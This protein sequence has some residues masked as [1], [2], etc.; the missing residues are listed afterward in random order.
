[1]SNEADIARFRALIDACNAWNVQ[2]GNKVPG[3][4]HFDSGPND[5]TRSLTVSE[6]REDGVVLADADGARLLLTPGGQV[7]DADGKGVL[8]TMYQFCPSETFLSTAD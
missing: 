4:A 2:V 3:E 5:P 6:R 7:Q 8:P 1:M